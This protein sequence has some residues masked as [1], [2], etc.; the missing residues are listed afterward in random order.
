MDY[1]KAWPGEGRESV[2]EEAGWTAYPLRGR[3]TCSVQAQSS[4]PGHSPV[5]RTVKCQFVRKFALLFIFLLRAHNY[6]VGKKKKKKVKFPLE[7]WLST[8][9][10]LGIS[11]GTGLP[12]LGETLLASSG[13]RPELQLSTPQCREPPSKGL[14]RP[15]CQQCPESESLLQ[16]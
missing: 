3:P 14:S 12:H 5:L 1:G 16:R 7:Q 8:G 9:D 13:R 10:H 15:Q 4:L 2:T 6:Y 11:A